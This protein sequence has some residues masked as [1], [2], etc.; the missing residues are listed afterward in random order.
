VIVAVEDGF[1]G[2]AHDQ[3]VKLYKL[4]VANFAGAAAEIREGEIRSFL[5]E[6]EHE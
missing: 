2:A 4:C 6:R 5:V 3:T 1:L